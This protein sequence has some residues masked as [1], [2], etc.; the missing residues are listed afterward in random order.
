M[1]ERETH[2][3]SSE[4]GLNTQYSALALGRPEHNGYA[5][6]LVNF[7][8]GDGYRRVN[9]FSEFGDLSGFVGSGAIA[10]VAVFDEAIYCAKRENTATNYRL[11][12]RTTSGN[13]WAQLVNG[14]GTIA[15]DGRVRH[16]K[17]NWSGEKIAFADGSGPLKVLNTSGGI[18]T[19]TG[20][21]FPADPKYVT[22]FKS[23]LAIAGHTTKPYEL[24]LTQANDETITSGGIALNVGDTIT[25]LR[26]FREELIIFC[27]SSIKKIT[28]S[29]TSDFA[30]VPITA[31]LGCLS[32]DSV[33]ELGG[34]LYFWTSDG[35]R[36][37]RGTERN[38]D[39]EIGSVTVPIRPTVKD[40]VASYDDRN[41]VATVVRGKS[42]FRLFFSDSALQEAK[43]EA[44]LG[45]MTVGTV[46]PDPH[47]E[48]SLLRGI[49]PSCAT[50]G[51]IGGKEYVMHGGFDGHVYR[52][53]QGNRFNTSNIIAVYK[54]P[55]MDL[56]DPFVRKVLHNIIGYIK[57]EGNAT[58]HI[59]LHFDYH[60]TTVVQPPNKQVTFTYSPAIYGESTTTYGVAIWD[61]PQSPIY[62]D[63]LQG[64]CKQLSIQIVSVA[65]QAPFSIH[66]FAIDHMKEDRQ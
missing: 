27:E 54:S 8:P 15:T 63:T 24:I 18:T 29:T 2:L 31:D 14:T 20:G 32:P 9:G 44:I 22:S 30:V 62:R 19:L 5:D 11:Y 7:E 55:F 28:G 41:M 4:G 61:S 21:L 33:F 49:N 17:F 43:A 65:N 48:F 35:L 57:L 47:W 37:I 39:I 45:V 12:K 52:Q 56:G 38:N 50:S 59:A 58:I 42:Q 3:V 25:Q 26:M 34:D 16:V 23:R 46:R 40:F 51:Y 53:E 36:P 6:L 64:S 1:G 10:G 60:D 13:A 66:G